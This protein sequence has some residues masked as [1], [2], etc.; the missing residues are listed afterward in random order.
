MSSANFGAKCTGCGQRLGKKAW[1]QDLTSVAYA[2]VFW[3]DANGAG[4]HA[5]GK[6]LAAFGLYE[7]D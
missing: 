1:T 6:V 4:E 7:T 3:A 5:R 2:V